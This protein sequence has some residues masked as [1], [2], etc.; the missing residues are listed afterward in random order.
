MGTL[1]QSPSARVD[2]AKPAGREPEP[3]SRPERLLE[4]S[5]LPLAVLV[6]L[7]AFLRY[8]AYSSRRLWFDEIYSSIV[9][10]QPNWSD[11]WNAFRLGVDLQ[12]PLFYYTT[13]ISWML[14]GR[15]ELALR[16]PEILGVL[17][18]S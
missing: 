8:C 6:T 5:A 13:R 9:A 18:F 16:M 10:L 15:N 1:L 4:K 3:A 2:S 17:L 11:V 7:I 12:P 14:L